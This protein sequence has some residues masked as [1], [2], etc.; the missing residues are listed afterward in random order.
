[1][2]H[3]TGV[4]LD[5]AIQGHIRGIRLPRRAWA[6]LERDKIRTLAQLADIAHRIE[7]VIPGIGWKTARMI[8][9]QLKE[10]PLP[11]LGSTPVNGR[12]AHISPE[13][14]AGQLDALVS[15]A[16][17]VSQSVMTEPAHQAMIIWQTV[18]PRCGATEVHATEA[19]SLSV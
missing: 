18:C 4:P 13:R 9:E 15:G 16:I 3:A 19:I 8:R 6:A 5:K 12:P 17:K 7:R 1:M 11:G 2:E 10:M 14:S